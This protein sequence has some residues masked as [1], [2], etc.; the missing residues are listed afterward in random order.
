MHLLT[1]YPT[2]INLL[3]YNKK[4]CC[5]LGENN[6]ILNACTRRSVTAL[7]PYRNYKYHIINKTS[8]QIFNIDLKSNSYFSSVI[9]FIN[10]RNEFSYQCKNQ[11]L[12]IFCKTV[13]FFKFIKCNTDVAF[14]ITI[15]ALSCV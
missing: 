8:L 4:H 10:V 5:G 3:L 6:G 7:P 9:S 14:V 2:C 11:K 12:R 1:L 15:T 13:F